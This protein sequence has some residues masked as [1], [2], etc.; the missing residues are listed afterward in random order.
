M[1]DKKKTYRK[2]YYEKNKGKLIEYG[3]CYYSN[4]KNP[5]VMIKIIKGEFRLYFD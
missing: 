4:K 1:D 5:T 3:K 2:S